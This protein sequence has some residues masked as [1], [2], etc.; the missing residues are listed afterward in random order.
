MRISGIAPYTKKYYRRSTAMRTRHQSFYL[1]TLIKNFNIFYL[2]KN[3][4][5]RG[6]FLGYDVSNGS[7][8]YELENAQIGFSMWR[9]D[10]VLYDVKRNIMS[11]NVCLHLNG[12]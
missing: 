8:T 12:S 11:E 3:Y 10:E 7:V 4:F 1:Y 6:L 2:K 9:G 5:N